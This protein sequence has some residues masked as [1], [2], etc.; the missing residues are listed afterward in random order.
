MAWEKIAYIDDLQASSIT[1]LA[2]G[3]VAATNVQAAIEELA[4][5]KT[6]LATVKADAD[7]ASAISLKH[8][9][10]SVSAP[11][12]LSTQAIS[13]VN[14]AAA[15][16]TEIDTGALANSDTVIPTSK[17]VTTAI[18]AGGGGAGV[19][20]VADTAARVALTGAVGKLAYQSDEAI[21]YIC[22]SI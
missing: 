10:V 17:A 6:T 4:D 20:V 7:V 8:A 15:T 18:A 5:E 14:D 12:S 1:S 9:A 19:T 22:K 16:V 3:D 13:L 2:H 21:M 11:I